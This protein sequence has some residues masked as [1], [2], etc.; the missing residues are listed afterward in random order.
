MLKDALHVCRYG[1]PKIRR[2]AQNVTISSNNGFF[3]GLLLW[4]SV[5]CKLLIH[6]QHATCNEKIRMRNYEAFD[7]YEKIAVGHGRFAPTLS[8][9]PAFAK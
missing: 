6:P 8:A 1:A 3:I 9:S 7:T 4:V 2:T 5:A